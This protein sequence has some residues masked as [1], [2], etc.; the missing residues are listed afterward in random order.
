VLLNASLG[1][2]SNQID[3]GPFDD[4]FN[5]S[6]HV[7]NSAGQQE[8]PPEEVPYFYYAY[9]DV[10]FNDRTRD[11][12]RLNSTIF[13]DEA[14]GSHEVKVGVEY[15]RIGWDDTYFR[16]GGGT[17]YDQLDGSTDTYQFQD[18][19][20]DG[21]F[22]D[23]VQRLEPFD[24][25]SEPISSTGDIYTA[26]A[27]DAWRPH[28][29][30]TV[31]PGLRW[32]NVVLQ[33]SIDEQIA[34]M[35]SWQPRVGIAWDI[36][37]NSKYVLRASGGRFMDPTA[38]TIPNF[39][40]GVFRTLA[41]YNTLEFYCNATRGALCD[42][43]QAPPSF[44]DPIYWTNLEGIEYVLF[45]NRGTP[46]TFEPAQTL[47]QAGLG[48]L[49][50]PYADEFIIAFET[51]V[52]RE[53]S[54][55]LT[56]V[57]KK[58]KEIIEDTCANNTWAWGDGE[59][60]NLDDES[61]W[62]TAGGCTNYVITNFSDFYRDYEAFIL[63]AQTRRDRLHLLAS[64]TYSESFGNTANGP[65]ESYAT[66]LADYY[67]AHF[68]N[69]EGYLPDH[70]EHRVKLNG[71]YLF[72][73]GWTIGFDGFYSSAGHQTVYAYCDVLNDPELAGDPIFEQ[74][75]TTWE[76]INSY[77]TT[78]DGANL[79]ESTDIFISKRGEYET[80]SVWQLDVQGSKTWNLRKLDLTVVGTVYNI[81][82]NEADRTFNTE[83]FSSRDVGETVTWWLPR[84]YEVG[85]RIEF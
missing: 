75:G 2:F 7:L 4:N 13:V 37:G 46:Q 83:A 28:P 49:E 1:L 12:L 20:G 73:K 59:Y 35:Q 72:P 47:D 61:T 50:A 76:Q 5:R 8:F 14:V 32:D 58:T 31:K 80:K 67:P 82:N 44:G 3:V 81:L 26:F 36:A 84:R 70:R 65:A 15:S 52:A 69:R 68:Y 9:P 23:W 79:G 17:I 74:Y 77:C 85:F 10:S 48:K 19:N 66:V 39:A 41:D 21:F 43:S 54:I 16:A 45:D 11:E 78:P 55:E 42:P 22:N 51:Q 34:D 38:L 27:Q 40:S 53:T 30:V 60:P 56:Y 33:N 18:I 24:V 64:Y 63:Q 6:G 62:T 29:N 57:N 25:V 71:Y